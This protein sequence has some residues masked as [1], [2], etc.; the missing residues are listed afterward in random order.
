MM[1]KKKALL[2]EELERLDK[3]VEV[4][5]YSYQRCLEIEGKES[6]SDQELERFE[7]LT[8]RFARLAD[9]LVQKIFRLIDRMDLEDQG[10]IRDR[11]NR[12]EKKGLIA[13]AEQFILIRE[14]RNAIAHE[15]DP[16]ATQQIFLNVL[17]F[18]P[19]LFDSVD[20]VKRYIVTY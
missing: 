7:S 5:Q 1:D 15:Y 9:L 16:E 10:T 19:L 18:C 17:A 11:I 13:S 12:A 3:S 2:I 6:F 14:L 8:G 4:L 20:R